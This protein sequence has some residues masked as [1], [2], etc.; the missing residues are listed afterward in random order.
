MGASIDVGITGD[1][2]K[3]KAATKQASKATQGLRGDLTKLRTSMKRV[4]GAVVAAKLAQFGQDAVSAAMGDAESQAVFAASLKRTKGV[5]DA[6]VESASNWISK[7]QLASGVSEEEL[8][9]ALAAMTRA[10]GDVGGA[11]NLLSLALDVSAG[12]GRSLESVTKDLTK[13]SQGSTAGLKK[14]Q[15]QTK[16]A[17]GKSISFLA[18]V[19]KLSDHFQGANAASMDTAAGKQKQ[20]SIQFGEMQEQLGEKL[21]PALTKLSEIFLDVA[22]WIERNSDLVTILA[23]ALAPLILAVWLLNAALLANPITWVIIGIVTLISVLVLAYTKVDWFRSA[24]DTAFRAIKTGV[25]V[26]I[27]AF[28]FAAP[29]IANVWLTIAGYILN[30]LKEAFNAAV[31]IWNSVAEFFGAESL[32]I[33]LK[34][35]DLGGKMFDEISWQQALASSRFGGPLDTISNQGSSW[36]GGLGRGG[37]TNVYVAGSVVT[38]R[39]L[40]ATITR[41]QVGNKNRGFVV[42]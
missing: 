15:I 8:R 40:A 11:Q 22:G 3:F 33:D 26:L 42:A 16:D 41:A 18:G 14:Y 35:P 39:Q 32:V 25:E 10:T 31:D 29:R 7:M 24:V 2:T 36:G 28:K 23:A 4:G 12:S 27:A 6:Q 38:E 13:A 30:P 34:L 21:L 5:T 19:Q 9:P 20:L 37:T 1:A 17:D